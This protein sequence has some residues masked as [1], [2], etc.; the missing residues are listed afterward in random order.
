MAQAQAIIGSCIRY[1]REMQ[2]LTL[3][4]LAQQA[5]I[6]Y[7][8]LSGVETGKQ[9]FSI[10]VLERLAQAL[11][12][13]LR[14]LISMSFDNH[15]G[16]L[17]PK[18]E[19]RFMRRSV[20]LPKGLTSE[21]LGATLDHAQLMVHRL[22]RNLVAEHGRPLQDIIQGNNFSGLVSNFLTDSFDRLS[23]YKHN[24]HQRHPDLVL[25]DRQG[26]PIEGLEVKTTVNVGKGGESHNGHEGWHVVACYN[27][28]ENGD[29]RFVHVMFAVLESHRHAS[30]PDWNYTGSKE[31]TVTGNHRTETFST[32]AFGT[33]KLRDGSAYLNT[34]V[35]N[36]SRWRKQHRGCVPAWS[37]WAP[38]V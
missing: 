35:V 36:I 20:P 1:F 32:N 37:I 5:G 31:N 26:R 14:V 4:S 11:N 21:Q 18:I 16:H 29:I 23:P 22:N 2:G 33:T 24:H 15:A 34:E 27:S 28:L 30:A 10:Q 17:P 13:P 6:S 3:E 12:Q 38:L 9:N 19:P 7:Q 25:S 8:Y